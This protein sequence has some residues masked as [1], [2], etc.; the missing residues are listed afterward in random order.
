MIGRSQLNKLVDKAKEGCVEA[1]DEVLRFFIPI[2]QRISQNIWHLLRDQSSFEQKCYRTL[3][4]EM[5][6]FDTSRGVF[7]D[8]ILWKFRGIK[9]DYIKNHGIRRE[10]LSSIEALAS[11]SEDGK[12]GFDIK[13]DLAIVESEPLLN[14]KVALLAEGD[15]RKLS[16][17]NVWKLG[18]Y[19]DSDTALL[20]AERHGGNSESQRKFITRFKTKCQIALSDAI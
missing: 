3:L 11:A 4:R 13:D 16:V 8:F 19:N 7:H 9:S 20:L 18:F 1:R 14:E 5:S 15:P 10:R 6:R 12:K 2:V 17:L